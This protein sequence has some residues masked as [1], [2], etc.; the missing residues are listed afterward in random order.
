[1]SLRHKLLSGALVLSVGR[2]GIYGFSFLR[3]LILARLLTKADYGLAASFGMAVSLLELTGKLAVDSQIIQAKDG[4]DPEFQASAHAFKLL[5]GVI[6]AVLIAAC[7]VP[8]AG[9]F[10]VPQA[11]WAF[12]A[13]GLVPLLKGLEH[14]DNARQQRNL[15]YTPMVVCEFTPQLVTTVLAWPVVVWLEDY[16]AIVV[17]TVC[18]SLLGI[19]MSHW[20]AE[21]GFQLSWNRNHLVRLAAFGWPFLCNSFLMFVCQQGDQFLIGTGY[22]IEELAGYSLA[23]SLVSIP[24][25][26]FAQTGSAL[27]LPV[28]S[29]CQDDA[30]RFAG[31][32]RRCVEITAVVA[33]ALMIP[34]ILLGEQTVS[35]LY[36]AKYEG[37]GYFVAVLA[38]A[39]A[40]R[41]I[42][43][44]PAI[45]AVARADTFNHLYSN[46]GRAVS[47]PLGIGVLALSGSPLLM[48][49]AGVVAEFIASYVSLERLRRKQGISFRTSLPALCFLFTFVV[50]AGVLFSTV[51]VRMNLA[52][53][54]AT[55]GLY[56]LMAAGIGKLVFPDA[57]RLFLEIIRR[58]K[59]SMAAPETVV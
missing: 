10:G 54:V 14:L 43:F 36:G 50:G 18:N 2:V 49:G 11:R 57:A 25:F 35:F 31:Q 12:A 23:Y 3:N 29:K 55:A 28:F 58:R 20:M 1:M 9:A 19:A 59:A 8:M 30:Q 47:F 40:V 16:R 53:A 27:M 42:R 46:V 22:S 13:L 44:T 21:R 24:W 6:S 5:A 51:T 52:G 48:A 15:V 38:A 41:F 45:A 32:Y 33:T 39:F 34:V 26:L 17:L 37:V 56:S 4:N 7:A